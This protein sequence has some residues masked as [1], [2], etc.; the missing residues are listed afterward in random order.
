M[1]GEVQ[2]GQRLGIQHLEALDEV[3]VAVGAEQRR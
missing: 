1:L 3:G 2:L